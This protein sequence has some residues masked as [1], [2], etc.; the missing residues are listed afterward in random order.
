MREA[1][2]RHDYE[3]AISHRDALQELTYLFDQ[4]QLLR[5]VARDYWFVYPIRSAGPSTLWNLIAGGD[6][7]AVATEPATK[8]ERKALG[9]LLEQTFMQRDR[10]VPLPF[11]KFDR[12]RLVASWFRQRPEELDKVMSPKDAMTRCRTRGRS[13]N[14]RVGAGTWAAWPSSSTCACFKTA[15]SPAFSAYCT[16]ALVWH[17]VGPDLVVH[18]TGNGDEF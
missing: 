2:E 13:L 5:D 7:V 10:Q 1:S 18:S 8:S 15:G 9:A 14:C 16:V 6:V 12:V 3:R 11:E 4:L 17:D